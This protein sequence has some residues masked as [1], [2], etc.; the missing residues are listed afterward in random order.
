MKMQVS[1]FHANSSGGNSELEV[2][3]TGCLQMKMTSLGS[4]GIPYQHRAHRL[5][6]LTLKLAVTDYLSSTLLPDPE[7]SVRPEG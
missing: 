2:L 5:G 7:I 1:G 4:S 3:V 6:T